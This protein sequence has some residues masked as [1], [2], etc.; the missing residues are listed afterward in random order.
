MKRVL[1]FVLRASLLASLGGA[2]GGS[3]EAREG[4]VFL[5]VGGFFSFEGRARWEDTVAVINYKGIGGSGEATIGYEAMFLRWLGLRSYVGIG[6]GTAFF[7]GIED[8]LRTNQ[9]NLL[10]ATLNLDLLFDFVSKDSVSFGLFV[11]TSGGLHYWHGPL[12][13]ALAENAGIRDLFGAVGLNAGLSLG[14]G[15]HHSIDFLTRLS[16]LDDGVSIKGNAGPGVKLSLPYSVGL[17]YI[18]SFG[19]G[20]F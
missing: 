1:S 15:S 6:Y 13:R 9:A 10:E 7:K 11:G 5:G 12:I 17:R 2:V 4:G 3:L 20:S 8:T 16:F 14:L 19:G 18:Y